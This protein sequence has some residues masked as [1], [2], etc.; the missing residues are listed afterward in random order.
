MF[1]ESVG[2]VRLGLA[3][4]EVQ[5]VHINKREADT[6]LNAADKKIQTQ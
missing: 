4:M 2:K 6:D 5:A 1:G 3:R